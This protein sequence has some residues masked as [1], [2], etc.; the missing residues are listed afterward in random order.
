MWTHWGGWSIGDSGLS[1]WGTSPLFSGPRCTPTVISKWVWA[2]TRCHHDQMIFMMVMMMMMITLR[3]ASFCSWCLLISWAIR[4]ARSWSA[5]ACLFT[6]SRLVI[7][8]KILQLW[9]WWPG[10][11]YW[12]WQDTLKANHLPVCTHA[13]DCPAPNTPNKR[14]FDQNQRENCDDDDYTDVIA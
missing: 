8:K 10:W 2:I 4:V 14:R 1:I 6:W 9:P 7:M 13:Q 12:R 3:K 11:S 5:L